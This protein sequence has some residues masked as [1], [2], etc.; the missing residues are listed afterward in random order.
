MK[1]LGRSILILGAFSLLITANALALPV[2]NH[3]V[4]MVADFSNSWPH[5]PYT[6]TDLDDNNTAY[7]TF[8][9]ESEVH[10][11]S[12]YTYVVESVED[13]AT[14]G[15]I[16]AVNGQDDVSEHSKW[17]YAAF[18]SDVFSDVTNAANTVQAAIWYWEEETSGSEAAWDLLNGYAFDDS[19]WT[20]KAVNLVDYSG[21]DIQ[22]QLVG[23][24][25]VPEPAT[26]LLLGTGLVGLAGFGRRKFKK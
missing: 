11:Y 15:G 6:M 10:F 25:P 3:H 12:G 26:M 23:V 1:S 17:L 14:G 4:R 22:S 16:G 18:M 19:G 5:T 13:Y 8:C 9:L 2:A 20:V 24:A 7:T 21:T